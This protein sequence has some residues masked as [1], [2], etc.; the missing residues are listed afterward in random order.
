VNANGTPKPSAGLSLLRP[1]ALID[2]C[3]LQISIA[4]GVDPETSLRERIRQQPG[5][6]E[7]LAAEITA[8]KRT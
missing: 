2:L 8:R 5:Q 3:M 1:R 4:T 6:R 7:Y